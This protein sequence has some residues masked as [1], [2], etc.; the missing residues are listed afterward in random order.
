[1]LSILLLL[2]VVPLFSIVRYA[3]S[4]CPHLSLVKL[5]NRSNPLFERKKKNP[6]LCQHNIDLM[7]LYVKSKCTQ[8]YASLIDLMLK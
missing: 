8:R 3:L 6:M 4:A 7:L 5:L 1:M 2:S